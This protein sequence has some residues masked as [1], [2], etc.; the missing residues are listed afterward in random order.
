M[1]CSVK[2]SPPILDVNARNPISKQVMM[3]LQVT[4]RSADIHP[5][6]ALRNMREERFA[7]FEKLREHTIFERMIL[8]ARNQI[9]YLRLEYISARVN[10]F[11]SGFL[12]LRLFQKSPHSSVILRLHDAIGAGVIN[13]RKHDGGECVSFLV[14]PNHSF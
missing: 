14:H 3:G 10:V 13:R 9:E 11:A 6:S 12:G 7:V 5:I 2:V 1:G 8:A 4:A